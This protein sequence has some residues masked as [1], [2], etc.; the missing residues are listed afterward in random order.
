[1]ARRISGFLESI[2]IYPDR[3]YGISPVTEANNPIGSYITNF[4]KP[5]KNVF[6]REGNLE[7]RIRTLNVRTGRR[8]KK[9]DYGKLFKCSFF[10]YGNLGSAQF[11]YDAF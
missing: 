4:L 9:I 11:D 7:S 3:L 5:L 8:W 10:D 1:M 6:F 2:G